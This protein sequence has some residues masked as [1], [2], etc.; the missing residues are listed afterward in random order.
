[1]CL[2]GGVVLERGRGHGCWG[3]GGGGG[4]VFMWISAPLPIPNTPCVMYM[5]VYNYLRRKVYI[6]V[7]LL[8]Y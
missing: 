7:A 6:G 2:G 1:M 8:N 4:Y 3:G 5:C